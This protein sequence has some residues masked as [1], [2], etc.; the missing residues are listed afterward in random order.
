MIANIGCTHPG[1]DEEI[2]VIFGHEPA[3]RE[4]RMDPPWPA[5]CPVEAIT[6]VCQHAQDD[7]LLEERL[8][9]WVADRAEEYDE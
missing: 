6:T 8:H 4:T 5:E 7:A 3:Q 1:C 2:E 9:E